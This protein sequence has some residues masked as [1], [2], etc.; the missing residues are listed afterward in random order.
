MTQGDLIILMPEE[1]RAIKDLAKK[2]E[3]CGFVC[4]ETPKKPRP[5]KEDLGNTICIPIHADRLEKSHPELFT[6]VGT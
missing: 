1:I 6:G 4:F 5:Y 2:I 3:T